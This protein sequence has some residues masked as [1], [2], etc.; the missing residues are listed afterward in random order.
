[1]G[2]AHLTGAAGFTRELSLLQRNAEAGALHGMPLAAAVT[3]QLSAGAESAAE[4]DAV[5][6][7]QQ[8]QQQGVGSP[9]SAR[10][11]QDRSR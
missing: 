1:M 5:E 3:R 4:A 8:Q 2:A 9:R 11:S 6:A 10:A 7:E